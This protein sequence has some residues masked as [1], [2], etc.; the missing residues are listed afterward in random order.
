MRLLATLVFLALPAQARAA[1]CVALDAERD[2]LS[3]ADRKATVVLFS[4]ALRDSGRTVAPTPCEDLWTLYHTRLGSSITVR[5]EHKGRTDKLGVS[6]I[7]E[8]PAAY[9]RLVR[10]ID[11]GTTASLTADRDSVIAAEEDPGRVT[12]DSLASLRIG[13]GVLPQAGYI[14]PSLG[15]GFRFELDRFGVE[16]GV[17]AVVPTSETE[18][19]IAGQGRLGALY[20]FNPEASATPYAGLGLGLGGTGT[21]GG[22]FF[23]LTGTATLGYSLLRETTIRIFPQLDFVSPIGT[24]DDG[25]WMPWMQLTFGIAY[26]PPGRRR[27]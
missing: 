18:P 5:V 9:E 2:N 20:F 23:G 26:V 16:L 14:G 12:A 15:A 27:R 17:E 24:E 19:F 4:D 25:D 6:T 10:A 13:L 7:E 8:L 1:S 3:P 22:A 11:G 21:D